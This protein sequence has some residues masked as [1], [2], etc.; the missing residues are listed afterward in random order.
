MISTLLGAGVSGALA[1]TFTPGRDTLLTSRNVSYEEA[2]IWAEEF[3][4]LQ[5]G[6]KGFERMGPGHFE[7]T[8]QA[9][10]TVTIFL[11]NLVRL[12]DAPRREREAALADYEANLAGMIEDADRLEEP[13]LESLMPVVRLAS[14]TSGYF[15]AD[16]VA[17]G[18]ELVSRPLTGDLAILLAVNSPTSIAFPTTQTLVELGLSEDAAFDQALANF[19]RFAE[20]LDWVEEGGLRMA[21]LDSNYE[22]SLILLDD[23]WTDL[24]ADMGGQIAV[25][26]PARGLLVAARADRSD[27]VATL[28]AIAADALLSPYGLSS[29]VF[30][31][32]NGGWEVLAP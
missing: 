17:E 25:A 15:G 11:D 5:P 21:V 13:V 9:D 4:A 12:M 20:I 19:A 24:E 3:L 7:V 31:R 23:V 1:Q 2:E 10:S 6:V 27:D 26:I 30:V 22:S 32:R 29:E 14:M 18:A 8:T 16:E 28:R